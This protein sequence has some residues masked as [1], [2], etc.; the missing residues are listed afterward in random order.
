MSTYVYKHNVT[1]G[2]I[3]IGIAD[4]YIKRWDNGKGYRDNNVFFNDI[5][6]YGWENIEHQILYK[7]DDRKQAEQLETKLIIEYDAENP[8]KGYNQTKHKQHRLKINVDKEMRTRRIEKYNE[9]RQAIKSFLDLPENIR[10]IVFLIYRGHINYTDIKDDLMKC[11]YS[12]QIFDFFYNNL[13]FINDTTI[14]NVRFKHKSFTD[15]EIKYNLSL[16]FDMVHD[17]Q[18]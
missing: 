18:K 14:E 6:R 1:N 11:E 9:I 8:E 4:D 15:Q 12:K 17:M 7:F 5:I 10:F 3:Y 13:V 16:M 2:K